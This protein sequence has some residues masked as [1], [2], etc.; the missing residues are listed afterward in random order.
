MID[1]LIVGLGNPGIRY[2]GTR[3]NIGFLCVEALASEYDG[4]PFLKDELS[5]IS[6]CEIGGKK[7]KI[8]KPET[9]M[10]S[11][12]DAV[13]Y[14]I[15]MFNIPKEKILVV[16][17]DIALPFGELRIKMKGSSG[18]HNGLKSI[19]SKIGQDYPRLKFGIGNNFKN[20]EQLKYVLGFWTQ[21]E[22]MLRPEK[23]EA[24]KNKII[25]YIKNTK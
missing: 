19:E 18:G 12:G 17:D 11:V 2:C 3:H 25:D 15:L 23:I 16:V 6:I 24:A 13:N 21:S 1:F 8:I 20:G 7:V 14:E 5:F 22:V 10:N 9:G 4:M